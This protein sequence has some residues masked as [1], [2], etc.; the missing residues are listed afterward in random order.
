[1]KRELEHVD[2]ASV[3]ARFAALEQEGREHLA[4]AGIL[5]QVAVTRSADMR[6]LSQRYEVSVPLPL[7]PL[8]PELMGR[9][10]KDFYAAYRQHYGREIHEVPVETVSW[11]LTVSGP[12]PAIAVAW[13]NDAS[14]STQP[15]LKGR[16]PVLYPSQDAAIDTPLYQRNLMRPDITLEGPAIIEDRESTTVVPPGAALRIADQMLTITLKGSR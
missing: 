14:A 15:S 13:P 3:N 7:E 9:L 8:G 16:R 12:P 1:M 5:E 2:W 11:R 4:K 10:R 6:Y